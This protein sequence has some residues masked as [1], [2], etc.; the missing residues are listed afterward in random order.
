M[1]ILWQERNEIKRWKDNEYNAADDKHLSTRIA[2]YTKHRHEIV[3][4][5]GQFLME[6]DMAQL[7]R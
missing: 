2:W 6:I 1:D 7:S 4:H 5:H 3:D